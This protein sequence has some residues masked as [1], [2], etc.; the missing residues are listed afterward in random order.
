MSTTPSVHSNSDSATKSAPTNP[1]IAR[2]CAAWQRRFNAEK[3]K[4]VGNIFAEGYAAASYRDAM[5]HL[6]DFEGIRDFIACTGHGMLIGAIPVEKG[7]KLLYAAQVAQS[8]LNRQPRPDRAA[9][10]PKSLPDN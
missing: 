10:R 3:E 6:I 2:C 1:A 9:G 5:P 4:G 8:L 7:A